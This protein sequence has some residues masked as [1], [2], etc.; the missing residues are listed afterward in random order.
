MISA[1]W[2]TV[3]R[4]S[5][6]LAAKAALDATGLGHHLM[7]WERIAGGYESTCMKCGRTCRIGLILD[8][9]IQGDAVEVS[10]DGPQ[11]A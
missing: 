10:C 7:A 9:K 6:E 1:I 4:L 8:P 3:T 2:S 5:Q 11:A